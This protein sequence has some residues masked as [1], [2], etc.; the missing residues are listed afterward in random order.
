MSREEID[1]GRARREPPQHGVQRLPA[2]VVA[3]AGVPAT[4]V[5]L[6]PDPTPTG[7]NVDPI[8]DTA[9]CL[10][11]LRHAEALD[12]RGGTRLYEVRAEPPP[13]APLHPRD[14]WSRGTTGV[15]HDGSRR[16]SRRT[17]RRRS[18]AAARAD[19]RVGAADGTSRVWRWLET[20]LRAAACA[21]SW[22][23][24]ASDNRTARPYR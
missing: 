23:A 3:V 20:A 7:P 16:R 5:P 15:L 10:D 8:P 18:R 4:S 24:R 21:R 6:S 11:R 14:R 17:S 19:C 22:R 2:D 13:A 1:S 12:G 9:G